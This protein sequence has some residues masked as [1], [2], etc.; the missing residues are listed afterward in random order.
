MA[1]RAKQGLF[2]GGYPRLGY[3]I[4]YDNKCLIPDESEIP[5]VEEAFKTYISK[6]SLSEAA[7]TL[8]AKG[9]RM[10]SWTSR[11][12]NKRGGY[13][14]NKNSLG[15]ILKDPI[16]IGKIKYKGQIYDGQQPAIVEESLFY[17]VQSMLN[18]NLATRTGYREDGHKFLLKSLV[19]CGSCHTAM[20]PSFSV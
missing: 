6:G 20:I 10:K 19:R 8:N 12:G 11:G 7:K 17:A 18:A 2:N 16:Y 13:R 5:I 1:Y 3:N 14:F 15:R 4:D 9:Y